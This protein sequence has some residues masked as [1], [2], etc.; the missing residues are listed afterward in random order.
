[1]LTW[2]LI[3]AALVLGLTRPGTAQEP[4]PGM[5]VDF[6]DELPED[7]M[8][9]NDGVMGGVSRSSLRWV[10][11]A[12]VFQGTLSLENNGGFASFRVAV[13]QGRLAGATRLMVRVRGDG[14]RYQLRLRPGGR[15]DGV[16]YA[17]EFVAPGE[18]TTVSLPLEAFE[19]TFRGFRPPGAGALDPGR[20]RQA[21][22][23]LTDKQ[24]GPFR[25]EVAWIG[26]ETAP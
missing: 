14:Q 21:G 8:I 9:V 3:T 24:D 12:G 17:A 16:A 6:R 22:L 18:W 23:M 25:V 19:A 5:L 13:E 10:D 20:V 1:M 26:F 4:P 2:S 11:G 15:F 7:G